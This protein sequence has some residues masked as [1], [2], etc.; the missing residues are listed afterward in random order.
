MERKKQSERR[1]PGFVWLGRVEE[2]WKSEP[3][4]GGGPQTKAFIKI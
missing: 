2:V 1:G 4:G 3:R